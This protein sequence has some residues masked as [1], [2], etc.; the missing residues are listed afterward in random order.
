[1][2]GSMFV[3]S[4]GYAALAVAVAVIVGG[5]LGYAFRGRENRALSNL[6]NDIRKKL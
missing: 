1:M 3:V 5:A 6:G 4:A 2:F